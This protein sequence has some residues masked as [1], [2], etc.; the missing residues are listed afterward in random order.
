MLYPHI[1]NN[2]IK[3]HI[4]IPTYSSSS[5][6]VY[7]DEYVQGNPIYQQPVMINNQFNQQQAMMSPNQYQGNVGTEGFVQGVNPYG[8]M[9]YSNFMQPNN[10]NI[11]FNM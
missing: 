6:N 8:Q 9:P 10:P 1:V 5:E 2:C 7:I 11:N 4:A 3:R